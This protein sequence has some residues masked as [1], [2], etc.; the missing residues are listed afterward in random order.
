MGRPKI[1]DRTVT[2]LNKKLLK[3][4]DDTAVMLDV[5]T[6]SAMIRKLLEYTSE[7]INI[8]EIMR[9]REGKIT[10]EEFETAGITQCN[11]S[12]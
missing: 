5:T 8:A 7:V 6:R 1:G 12:E 3:F 9:V 4:I 2:Y 11:K 10:P